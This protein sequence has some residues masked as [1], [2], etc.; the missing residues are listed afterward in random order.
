MNDVRA[1]VNAVLDAY[2]TA[3]NDGDYARTESFCNFPTMFIYED[4]VDHWTDAAEARRMIDLLLVDLKD[5]NFGRSVYRDRT[6][7][8]LSPKLALASF[9]C[10]RVDQ[11][12]NVLDDFAATY[13]L[14][15]A[16]DGWKIV[17]CCIH[18]PETRLKDGAAPL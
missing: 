5:R 2:V 10:N 15:K 7:I 17:T 14:R 16:D 12:D 6:I 1:E 13:T 18:P 11:D 3:F 4:R 9:R 8:P